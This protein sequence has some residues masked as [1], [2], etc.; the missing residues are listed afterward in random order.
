MNGAEIKNY[1][2]DAPQIKQNVR[3][4]DTTTW[5]KAKTEA[6]GNAYHDESIKHT[7]AVP[8]LLPDLSSSF[9]GIWF[10]SVKARAPPRELLQTNRT[11]ST[12]RIDLLKIAPPT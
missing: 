7:S 8:A 2:Y 12:K 5:I 3:I 1:N 10:S 11:A 4:P 9:K 6:L